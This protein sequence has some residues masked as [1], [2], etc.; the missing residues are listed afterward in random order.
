M[1][2]LEGRVAIITGSGRGIG[3][4]HALLFAREGA[5]VIVNDLG[6]ATDGTSS[7]S[8][9]AQQVADEINALGGQAV[10]NA[11]SV[12]SWLGAENLVRTAVEAFGD[13]H[14]LVNNAG[15]LRDRMIVN[16]SEEEWDTVLDVHLKG[17]F[18]PLRAAAVYWRQQTKKGKAVNAAIVNTSSGS[19]F[20]GNVGQANYA[21]AKSGIL[22]LTLVAARELE[23]YGVRANAVAPVARTRLMEASPGLVD[24]FQPPTDRTEFDAWDPAN[25]SPLVAYLSTASCTLTGQA[26]S[27]FGGVVVRN[28]G[29]TAG[30][31]FEHDGRWDIPSLQE[32][33]KNLD[34]RLL[35]VSTTYN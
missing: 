16:M 13:L 15:I 30:D 11:D 6:S 5:K 31:R 9:A 27:A 10:A 25:I 33:L 29:W 35:P 4:E 24:R 7:D 8:S 19:G 34:G 1:S 22:T 32:A 18:C 23:Q 21:A 17:H 14:I 20:F 28:V 12:S 3:R 2:S 26:F